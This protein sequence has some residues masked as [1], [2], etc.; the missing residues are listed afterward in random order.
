MIARHLNPKEKM[1]HPPA[2]CKR[3]GAISP[4]TSILLNNASNTG[5]YDLQ[6]QDCDVC[7]GPRFVLDGAYDAF[8]D[9]LTLL[10]GPKATYDALLKA[11]NVARDSKAA[12][13]S[14]EKTIERVSEYLPAFANLKGKAGTAL[15]AIAFWALTYAATKLVDVHLD[16]L[17][18]KP[19]ITPAQL[20]AVVTDSVEKALQAREEAAKKARVSEPPPRPVAPISV[21]PTSAAPV[22]QPPQP[23]FPKSMEKLQRDLRERYRHKGRKG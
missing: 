8:G 1:A 18:K 2:Q 20:S 4:A 12:G 14:V 17:I 13:E 10:S 6:V 3:C 16:P 19:D 23:K 7:G 11:A 22:V 21:A 15:A 5:F 9:V